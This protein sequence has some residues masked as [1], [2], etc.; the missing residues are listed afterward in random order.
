[1]DDTLLTRMLTYTRR[2]LTDGN[3]DAELI[4]RE[5]AISVR[6]LYGVFQRAGLSLEQ[7]IISERLEGAR[8]MLASPHLRHLTI[9]AVARRWGFANP[10]HFSRRFRAAYGLTPSEWRSSQAQ[11]GRPDPHSR[12]GSWSPR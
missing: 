7:W 11:D 6:H 2:H 10:G 1:M 5:H 9:A 4:A 3:L 8:N 12:D